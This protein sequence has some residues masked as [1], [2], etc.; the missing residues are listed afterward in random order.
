MYM[1]LNPNSRKPEAT[2]HPNAYVGSS[3]H[4]S[5]IRANTRVPLDK[6]SKSDLLVA[7][8]LAA[9]NVVSYIMEFLAVGHHPRL[10]R[11]GSLNPVAS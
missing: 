3:P 5:A 11:L 9:G 2:L 8:D 4:V 10:C 1:I 6:V 7:D